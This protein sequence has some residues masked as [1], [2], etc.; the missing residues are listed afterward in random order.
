MTRF[1]KISKL[2]PPFSKRKSLTKIKLMEPTQHKNFT[3]LLQKI[4]PIFIIY[5]ISFVFLPYSFAEK[6][7]TKKKTLTREE[8]KQIL[9]E[10]KAQKKAELEARKKA[11]EA[12]KARKKAELEAKRKAQEAE[13]ERKK[14]ELKA[15]KAR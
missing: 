13:R 10:E 11:Q 9:A 15:Q 4:F 3:H 12:E 6:P 7:V 14:Q 2:V 5:L 1:A 8:K